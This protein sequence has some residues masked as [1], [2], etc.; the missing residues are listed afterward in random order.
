MSS[1]LPYFPPPNLRQSS[2]N[3]PYLSNTTKNGSEEPFEG[4]QDSRKIVRLI[5]CSQC[6]Y[7]L[8]EPVT[9]PC[10]NSICK[11]CIPK[12]HDREH[13]SYPATENRRQGFTCP[14][15]NCEKEHASGDCSLDVDLNKIM[16]LIRLC[17]EDYSTSPQASQWRVATKAKNKW[18]IAGIPSLQDAPVQIQHH[19][20]GRLAAAYKM[21]ELGD[22][23]Y[24]SEVEFTELSAVEDYQE[25]PDLELL[26]ILRE[27]LR[28]ELD[29]QVCYGLFLD[30]LTTTCGHTLC[31]KCLHRVQDHSNL[32][33]ICRRVL[34][35]PPGASPSQAPSNQLLSKLISG[36]CSEALV[37]RVEAEMLEAQS[38]VGELDTS[39]FVCTLSF[40]CTPTFLHIFE[41]RYRLM[42]RRAI[43]SGDRKFGMILHNPGRVPQGELGRVPFFQY[44]TLLHV[45]DAHMLPDGRSIIETVGVSRFR[46]LQYG[47]L[48][49]YTVGK[50]ERID[51]ISVAEEEANE[52]AE[53]SRIIATPTSEKSQYIESSRQEDLTTFPSHPKDLDLLPTQRLMDICVT[54]VKRMQNSSAPWLH[55]NVVN[56]YGECPEDPAI[57]PWWFASVIPTSEIEKYKMLETSSVRERLKMCVLFAAELERQ[58][59]QSSGC[60]VI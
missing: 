22:L 27:S 56:A 12:L 47:T 24:D 28:S 18:A 38:T 42:I 15:A 7:P 43:E 57:F 49:G 6:S 39:L 41:P 37:D 10:G 17:I 19:C 50:V 45:I 4:F 26:R 60:N 13:I 36:L 3:T 53:T 58:R 51:D 33:P 40:P 46:V 21:A 54:F 25:D 14:F 34:T 55:S 44:G 48:D 5:Q 20:G 8:R 9:L 29:C 11:G 30:P 1:P 32:C 23:D 2:R 35:M 16:V 31:R 59:C 52:A